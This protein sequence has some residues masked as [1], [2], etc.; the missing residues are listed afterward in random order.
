MHEINDYRIVAK[1]I[2]LG[3]LRADLDPVQRS[4]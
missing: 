2:L 4:N 3:R 1:R